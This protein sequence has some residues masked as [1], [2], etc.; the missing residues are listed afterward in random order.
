LPVSTTATGL[1]T[2]SLKA[3]LEGVDAVKELSAVDKM[4][5]D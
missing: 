2:M 4:R 3:R 5:V 1:I